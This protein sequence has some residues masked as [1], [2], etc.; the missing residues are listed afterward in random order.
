V[1][2]V[3]KLVKQYIFSRFHNLKP[4]SILLSNTVGSLPSSRDSHAVVRRAKV[5]RMNNER[6]YKQMK[7]LHLREQFSSLTPAEEFG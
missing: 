7:D 2:K 4:L 5:T 1:K 6:L 3:L